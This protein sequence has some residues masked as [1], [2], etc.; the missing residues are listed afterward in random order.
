MNFEYLVK[1]AISGHIKEKQEQ[2]NHSQS[3]RKSIDNVYEPDTP[4]YESVFQAI[5]NNNQ[6]MSSYPFKNNQRNS[7]NSLIDF[8]TKQNRSSHSGHKSHSRKR[9][10]SRK[11]LNF[12]KDPVFIVKEKFPLKRILEKAT[13]KLPNNLANRVSSYPTSIKSFIS[14]QKFENKGTCDYL[15]Y[16]S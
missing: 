4:L 10:T 16:S 5:K 7:S 8:S 6:E 9:K 12:T 15:T 1:K 14:K 2:V 11:R 13:E 3:P